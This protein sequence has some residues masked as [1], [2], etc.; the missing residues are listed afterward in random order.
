MNSPATRCGRWT[1]YG[2]TLCGFLIVLQT[3]WAEEADSA[4]D[5]V[6][7][8]QVTATRLAFSRELVPASVSVI[9]GAE[10]EALGARDL[11]TAMSLIAG[12][13]IA[14]GGD[15]GPAGSVPGMWG[16]R[17]FDAFLL[18]VDGV[19]WGGAFNPELAAILL[20]DVDR[21]EVLRGAAP[22]IYGATSFVGVIHVIHHPAGE[23]DHLARISY[24]SHDSATLTGSFALPQS[25]SYRQSL[26]FEGETRGFDDP[27]AGVDSGHV[28]Y[29][30]AMDAGGGKL[31]FDANALAL[32][33]DPTSPQLRKGPVL[34]PDFPLDA[35]YNPSDAR[36]D[37]DFYQLSG[38][39]ELPL[40][41]N[42]WL[43]TLSATHVKNDIVR[44]FIDAE[45]VDDGSTPNAAGF[46]QD[47]DTDGIYFDTHIAQALNAQV[48]LM[49]GVDYLYGNAQQTSD[50][51]DY[52]VPIDGSN[53]PPSGIL[54]IQESVDLRDRRNF[55]GE[56]VQLTAEFAGKFGLLAGF[57][58][59]QTQENR[60]TVE[61]SADG[62]E[63]GGSDQ[64]SKNRPGG[65]IGLSWKMW[66]ESAD[67]L[68]LYADYRNSYKPA[69]IDFG[70]EAES[71][72][73]E[74][75]TGVS[76]EAGIRGK[77]LGG[78]LEFEANYFDMHM[79]NL[80]VTQSVDGRPGLTNAGKEHFKGVEA[81]ARYHITYDLALLGNYAWHDARFGD[82]EQLFGDTLT[83]LK[84]KRLEMSP[85]HLAA[86]GLVYHPVLGLHGSVVWN[87]IGSQYLNKR[88]TAL[89][90]SY[91][92]WDVT[93]GWRLEHW[94][95]TLA[96]YN[97]GD[98]R[99]PVAESEL[100]EGQYYRLPGRSIE[101]FV[102]RLF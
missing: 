98:E 91:S 51:F 80:V 78:Q 49:Y 60:S 14:P 90:P 83:Q 45:Y 26:A 28:L 21:I 31:Q 87:Y 88:N 97:L 84:G 68:T 9:T 63:Q 27:E 25:G 86:L 56:Y 37:E 47:R 65:T 46:S 77:L 5:E 36:L 73:L 23:S 57:R 58:L 39:Y 4:A 48:Q 1:L 8:I 67:F 7:F 85:D 71:D 76:Y 33:Q 54:P 100:G 10:L 35:N 61:K 53:A 40:G 89:A 13:D 64:R 34:D 70:P 52:Y 79:D 102:T 19:P 18:V 12:V 42:D 22:V 62:M 6:E 94:D 38:S 92:T 101:M 66:Q 30:G 32:R 3:A 59:N 93:L 15:G 11:R 17:E 81:E 99:P 44:G 29:R 41:R 75:E 20:S 24:G 96:G 50:N 74:P 72:I 43:T 55:Y 95:F 16:L 2:A 82:Y 69:A